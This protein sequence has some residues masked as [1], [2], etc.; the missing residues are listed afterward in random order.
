[1][2]VPAPAIP[3]GNAYTVNVAR[4]SGDASPLSPFAFAAA[5]L[6]RRWKIPVRMHLAGDSASTNA[7]RARLND[8]GG[9]PSGFSPAPSPDV[10]GEGFWKTTM[11]VVESPESPEIPAPTARFWAHERDDKKVDWDPLMIALA[12][13]A[14]FSHLPPAHIARPDL[15]IVALPDVSPE[16]AVEPASGTSRPKPVTG[17]EQAREVVR[18]WRDAGAGAVCLVGRD[19][20][21]W[22]TGNAVFGNSTGARARLSPP[23]HSA[24][25][26]PD[27]PEHSQE[28]R[29][30][31][32]TPALHGTFAAGVITGLMRDLLSENLFD[33]TLL[34]VERS[35]LEMRPLRLGMAV[36]DG[37]AALAVTGKPPAPET[38]TDVTARGFSEQVEACAA[39]LKGPP[40]RPWA[41]KGR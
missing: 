16:N 12:H 37:L 31:A 38:V 5:R 4:P 3:A 24:H 20:I 26:N 11:V 40:A 23:H 10:P 14:A 32:C 7:L 39:R 22:H 34:R 17:T 33:K 15:W 27:G 8:A 35:C 18:R 30:P 25:A 6:L 29:P 1:M 28:A 2:A 41:H 21:L 9:R 36:I 13:D 19:E